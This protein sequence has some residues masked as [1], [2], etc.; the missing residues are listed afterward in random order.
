MDGNR[1]REISNQICDCDTES[2]LRSVVRDHFPY[3]FKGDFVGLNYNEA[4][5]LARSFDWGKVD[6]DLLDDANWTLS[7]I[8]GNGR[9]YEKSY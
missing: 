8:Q 2:R 7:T 1:K 5:R 4:A 6:A 9:G 3:V